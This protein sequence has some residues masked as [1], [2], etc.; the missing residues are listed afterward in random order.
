MS[1]I[2]V[3]GHKVMK[4]AVDAISALATVTP[5]DLRERSAK[6]AMEGGT[7][8]AVIDNSEILGVIYLKDTMKPGIRDQMLSL[9]R[10]GIRTVMITGDNRLT[11]A[12]IAAEAGVQD[13]VAEVNSRQR[14]GSSPR[15]R[16]RAAWWQ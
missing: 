2:E 10:A 1:G 7:P 8:L 11:A 6:I 15:S 14:S 3:N 16:K 4:G 13:F 5:P 9:R 12:T